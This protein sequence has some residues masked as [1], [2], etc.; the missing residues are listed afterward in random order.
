M[1]KIR[2]ELWG[3]GYANGELVIDSWDCPTCHASYEIEY[4]RYNFCPQCG[5]AIDWEDDATSHPRNRIVRMMERA[6]IPP[7]LEG[8]DYLIE[9]VGY[10]EGIPK[11]ELKMM[12]VY[13]QVANLNGVSLRSVERAMRYAIKKAGK[14]SVKSFVVSMAY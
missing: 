2:P 3:D 9:A 11:R 1:I 10:A 5:Q 12:E 13:E 8:Y 7:H 14:R 4:E 6:G